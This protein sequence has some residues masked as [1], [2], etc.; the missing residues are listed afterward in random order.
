MIKRLGMWMLRRALLGWPVW[1]CHIPRH[2]EWM[3]WG[4][5][6]AIA[7]LSLAVGVR[8]VH[9][10]K[11]M[12]TGCA[13]EIEIPGIVV[14]LYRREPYEERVGCRFCGKWFTSKYGSVP[15]GICDECA[16]KEDGS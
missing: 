9:A 8:V 1:H 10:H 11:V 2:P 15:E 12:G 13:V 4:L 5:S 6:V 3:H 16:D 7:P 14:T